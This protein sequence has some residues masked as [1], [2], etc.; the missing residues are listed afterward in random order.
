MQRITYINAYGERLVFGGEP[1]VLL[2]SV[3]GLGRPD[4]SIVKAQG[5]YQAGEMFSRVQL[6]A[7]YIGVQFDVLPLKTREAMYEERMRIERVLSSGRSARN[8]EIGTLIYENDA[9]AWVARAVP[10]G[11]IAYGKRFQNGFAASKVNFYCPDAYLQAREEQNAQLRMGDGGFSLPVRFPVKLGARR[12]K[13][14]LVNSGTADAPMEIAI[15]GTGETPTLVNHTTGAKIVVSRV[16]ANG[17]RLVIGTDPQALTCELHG[18][19]GVIEDAFGYLDPSIA[20]SSFLLT[21]GNNEVEYVP[22]VVSKQSRVEIR[23][24]AYYEGV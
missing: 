4:A 2:R 20:V 23:W 19:D 5:A 17:E 6:P 15:Y 18:A 16:V 14:M 13:G 12:F 1:P 10:D 11:T 8:G 24:H 7:R 3:T 22:S 9:G 21:P